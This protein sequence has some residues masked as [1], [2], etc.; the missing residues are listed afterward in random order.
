VGQEGWLSCCTCQCEHE[1]VGLTPIQV[2][3]AKGM[4]TVGSLGSL[5]GQP[6]LFGEL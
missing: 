1:F 5:A 6:S 3:L 2:E 4:E